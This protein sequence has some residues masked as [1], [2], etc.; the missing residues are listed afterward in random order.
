MQHMKNPKMINETTQEFMG[1]RY[2][3]CGGRYFS[4]PKGTTT[5]RGRARKG[6]KRT[7]PRGRSFLHR[8]VWEAAHGSI[9]AIHHV[10]HRDHDRSNNSLGNLQLMDRS[11][12]LASHWTDEMRA[13]QAKRIVKYAVPA[14]RAWHAS[15]E[16]LAWHSENGKRSYA[17]RKAIVKTCQRCGKR[18]KTKHRGISK[19]CHQNC[20][21]AALRERR[22][23][24]AARPRSASS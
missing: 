6:E 13:E 23:S 14:A 9:P 1:R 3:R 21:Q 5:K 20:K 2:W 12:H 8:D 4:R 10:H 18:Y 24:G 17:K 7:Q 15:P 16:G 11:E 19:Y 22:R